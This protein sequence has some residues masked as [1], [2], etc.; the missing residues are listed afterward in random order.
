MHCRREYINF[1][2]RFHFVILTIKEDMELELDVDIA[3]TFG[4]S[5]DFNWKLPQRWVDIPI[6]LYGSSY[7][8][9][10]TL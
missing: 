10:Q 7:H 2:K 3:A 9:F 5:L 1:F 6:W 8:Q 4:R